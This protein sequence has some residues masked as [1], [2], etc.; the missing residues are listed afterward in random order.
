MFTATPKRQHAERDQLSVLLAVTLF[1]AA[2][3]RFVELPTFTWGI[4]HILGSPLGFSLT[5]DWM[6]AVLMTGLVATGT[7]SIMQSHPLHDKQ[8][9]SIVFSLITPSIGTL[10]GSLFLIRATTWSAWLGTLIL[11]GIFIG[12]LVHFSYRA[13]S[14]DSSGYA[15]SRTI[16]NVADYLICFVLFGLILKSQGRALILAPTTFVITGMLALDLLSAA[17]TKSDSVLLFGAILALLES[18]WV[19]V[20]GYWP[21]SEWTAAASLTL[22]LYLLN[23]ILYQYLLKR[24]TQRVIWEFAVVAICV[25]MMVLWLKP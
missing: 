5:G 4:P 8:E 18:E 7:L 17:G 22:I 16:L 9:R 11:D 3:F 20:L 15:T 10:L 25:L 23:G 21:V 1:C 13:T 12:I 24:L 19:W 14:P 2:L 6:L